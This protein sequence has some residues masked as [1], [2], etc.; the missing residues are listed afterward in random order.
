MTSPSVGK[1]EYYV[2]GMRKM[3][4]LSDGKS[5]AVCSSHF[6]RKCTM[7]V[8]EFEKKKN[9]FLIFVKT[10]RERKTFSVTNE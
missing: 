4:E 3:K 9:P 7:L 2:A 8:Y 1:G 6:V 5:S 10:G